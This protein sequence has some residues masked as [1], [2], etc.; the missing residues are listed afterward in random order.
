MMIHPSEICSSELSLMIEGEIE[1]PMNVQIIG[2][3]KFIQELERKESKANAQRNLEDELDID[4]EMLE[5][6]DY[7]SVIDLEFPSKILSGENHNEY[8]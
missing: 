3:Q 6:H 7:E 8:K 5:S 1:L 4:S 2:E